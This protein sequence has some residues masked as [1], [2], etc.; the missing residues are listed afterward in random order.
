MNKKS[1]IFSMIIMILFLSGC[2]TP[3]PSN[4]GAL[5]KEIDKGK[6]I[7]FIDPHP[8]DGELFMSGTFALASSRG[9]AC[10]IV[11]VGSIENVPPAFNRTARRESIHWF[12]ETYLKEYVILGNL[13][14]SNNQPTTE[15]E[16]T[17]NK[18]KSQLVDNQTFINNIKLQLVE[19]INEKKPDIIVT[20]TPYGYYGHPEHIAVSKI[21]TDIYSQLSYKPKI[22][23]VINMDQDLVAKKH[24]EYEKYTPTD[25]INLQNYSTKLGKTFWDAKLEVWE[26]YSSSVPGLSQLLNNNARIQNNDEKEYFMKVD[27]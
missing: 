19:V 1:L 4:E 10:Y 18:S 15:E 11:C 22:Y 12:N 27:L 24:Y 21:V 5:Q 23:Y 26:H 17:G 3:S 13:Y 9:N 25:V 6:S 8:D 2:L 7:M 16:E 20:F 14:H